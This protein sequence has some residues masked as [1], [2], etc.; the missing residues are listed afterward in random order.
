MTPIKGIQ[1][2]KLKGLPF[3]LKKKIMKKVLLNVKELISNCIYHIDLNNS[4]FTKDNYFIN[5]QG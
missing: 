3:N 5:N 2:Q 4:P 1:I